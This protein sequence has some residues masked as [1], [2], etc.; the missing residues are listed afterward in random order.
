MSVSISTDKSSVVDSGY[1]WRPMQTCPLSRKVQLL[2]LG[3]VAVYGQWNGSDTFWRG[4]APLPK[5]PK[6]M[7]DE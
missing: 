2:G 5:I 6:E 7:R 4:W 3:G 1:F